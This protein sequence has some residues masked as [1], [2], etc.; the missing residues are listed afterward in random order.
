MGFTARRI[1]KSAGYKTFFMALGEDLL[2]KINKKLEPS[3]SISMKFRQ[4]D[5]VLNTD[6]EG[7]AIQLFIGKANEKGLIQG[8][9][10]ARTLKYDREGKLIK[11][12][13]ERK[14]KAS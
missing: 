5:L 10:Y 12:H 14:G 11:D 7:N 4:Y 3:A 8:E 2:K 9:R 1:K 6:K 13:W